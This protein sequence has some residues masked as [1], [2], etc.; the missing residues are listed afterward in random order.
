MCEVTP[1][2]MI[3]MIGGRDVNYRVSKETSALVGKLKPK[4]LVIEA[5]TAT[6]LDVRGILNHYFPTA[7]V[8]YSECGAAPVW[9][10]CL[11][12]NYDLII[13]NGVQVSADCLQC[14]ESIRRAFDAQN[15]A[16]APLTVLIDK[17]RHV[18]P[19]YHSFFD[20]YLPWN[21]SNDELA[22]RLTALLDVRRVL[23][24]YPIKLSQWQLV[25]VLHTSDNAVVF[26]AEDSLQERAVIKRF[27]FDINGLDHDVFSDFLFSID[28]LAQLQ[29][30]GLVGI[31]EAGVTDDAI[32][33][34]MDYVDGLTLKQVLADHAPQDE[35]R[36]LSWFR[37]IAVTLGDLHKMSM[38]HRDLKTSNVLVR[39]DGSLVLLD[40][41]VESRLLL[42][43]GFVCEDEI[44][45]T[46][47]YVSP[48]RITGEAA[49]V[50][51][52]LY[53]LGIL[54]YELLV[55]EKPFAGDSLTE[56]LQQHLFDPVPRLPSRFH[57]YQVLLDKLLAKLPESRLRSVA[58]V[59]TFI[60]KLAA[61]VEASPEV[62]G[63]R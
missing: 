4:F 31:R 17:P 59:L 10:S 23:Q 56:V 18:K 57:H 30:P 39:A 5:S 20:L 48:E 26:L 19:F 45:C 33:L 43:T 36:L 32:Y 16:Y 12:D 22:L 15:N 50:Q 29:H 41:G 54:L 9:G 21:V 2:E 38:L 13:V 44:Y 28:L 8:E 63:V 49:S 7:H 47:Y 46:P 60:D 34:L 27:K 14:F 1:K 61:P 35:R 25:E 53:A 37:Q 55:G 11:L 24:D 52:D 3:L 6:N 40:F 42:D 51:S 62:V 58:E